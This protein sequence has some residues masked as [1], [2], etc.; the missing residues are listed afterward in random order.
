MVGEVNDQR[1]LHTVDNMT[2][3]PFTKGMALAAL[4]AANTAVCQNGR[5]TT[6]SAKDG[7]IDGYERILLHMQTRDSA[8]WF[9]TDKGAQIFKNEAWTIYNEKNGLVENKVAK[10]FQDSK[11][12]IW[13]G[14]YGA[15]F[16][17]GWGASRAYDGGI[18]M[19]DGSTWTQYRVHEGHLKAPYVRAMFEDS[20]GRIWIASSAL[21]IGLNSRLHP[22]GLSLFDNGQWVNLNKTDNEPPAKFVKTFFEDA[23][24]RIWF[25]TDMGSIFSWDGQVF[26]EPGKEEGYKEGPIHD[27]RFDSKKHLW[28]PSWD[29]V[30]QFDGDRWIIHGK[31]QGLDFA[32]F[33]GFTVRENGAGE[34]IVPG[35]QGLAVYNGAAWKTYRYDHV[36]P[37]TP[38]DIATFS[39][40]FDNS[41]RLWVYYNSNLGCYADGQWIQEKKK[42]DAR[43][44]VDAKGRLWV[45]GKKG[46]ERKVDGEWRIE[47][48]IRDVYGFVDDKLGNL[49]ILS[50]DK[51][52]FFDGTAIKEVTT[53][54]GIPSTTTSYVTVDLQGNVWMMTDKGLCRFTYDAR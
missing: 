39:A 50:K 38:S 14:T 52:H 9:F 1:S 7:L 29:R 17:D 44:H 28:I 27:V 15:G 36:G 21:G 18:A 24:G 35:M 42:L 43:L 31:K 16:F 19:L 25:F 49:W 10:A 51:V 23:K 41:G 3:R 48:D 46:L 5:W 8:L 30:V 37:Y 11:G 45:P 12:R 26:H 4:L 32:H 6:Y 54:S 2:A 40:V 22:G 34:I 53:A 13:L 20:K 33:H 47:T